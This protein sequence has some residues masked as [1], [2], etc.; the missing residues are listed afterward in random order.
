MVLAAGEGRRF[1]ARS[2]RFKL[3]EPGAD[4]RALVRAVCETALQTADD[5]V[6]VGHHH[7]EAVAKALSGLDL[8]HVHCPGA[9]SGMGASIKCG[10]AQVPPSHAV[11]ILL[12][13]MPFVHAA[14]IVRVRQALQEG[15]DI[16]RP[17]FESRPGHPVG[18]S[19]RFR[20]ALLSIDDAH[21]AAPLIRRHA[22]LVTWIP[23]QDAGCVRDVDVPEDLI[24]AS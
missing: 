4:G 5:V 12:A 16:A 7:H 19:L 9:P 21:G 13:D 20:A 11:M 2:N 17:S 3:L 23:V 18:F 8:R 22:G 1:A 15:A 24:Q 6:V 10:L 14:T